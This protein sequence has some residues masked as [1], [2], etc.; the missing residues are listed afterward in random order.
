MGYDEEVMEVLELKE[1]EIGSELVY[2]VICSTA[3]T[4]DQSFAPSSL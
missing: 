3:D 4:V 2:S 1:D